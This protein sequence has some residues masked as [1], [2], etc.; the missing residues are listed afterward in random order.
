MTMIHSQVIRELI[1]RTKN[2]FLEYFRNVPLAERAAMIVEIALSEGV[3]LASIRDE[4]ESMI[5]DTEEDGS[6]ESSYALNTG[7]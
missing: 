5:P 6:W 1:R 3:Q 4:L 7:Q 2:D